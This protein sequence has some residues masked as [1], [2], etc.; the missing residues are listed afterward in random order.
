MEA[1]RRHLPQINAEKRRLR[2]IGPRID[3]KTRMKTKSTETFALVRLYLQRLSSDLRFSAS[4][5]G[6]KLAAN[7]GIKASGFL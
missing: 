5:C 7:R 6:E 1:R 3:A 4:I 2:T